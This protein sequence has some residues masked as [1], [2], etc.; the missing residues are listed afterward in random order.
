MRG[1]TWV[2]G[3]IALCFAGT[4]VY[5]AGELQRERTSHQN[6][7]DVRAVNAPSAI[8]EVQA[9]AA[10]PEAASLDKVSS[11][12]A[13]ARPPSRERRQPSE[14]ELQQQAI[15]EGRKFLAEISTPAGR[16]RALEQMKLM[17]RARPAGL[18][19]FLHMDAE[20]YSQFVDLLAAQ[21]LA[22]REI[23]L[24]CI[25][26]KDCRYSGETADWSDARDREI[27]SVFGQETVERYRWFERSSNE[28]QAVTE[29]R[30]HLP[31]SARLTDAKAE[32]LVKAWVEEME[33]IRRDMQRMQVGVGTFNGLTFVVM[34]SDP[35][36]SRAAAAD[37]YNR[38]MRERAAGVLTSEQLAVL[39]QEQAE[40]IE[41]ARTFHQLS[42]A[43]N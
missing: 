29:L 42:L 12:V 36:G 5:F 15:E 38:R 11:D 20:Q 6:S 13:H 2:L 34:E 41:Q 43:G 28:R 37:D 8:V 14:E 22:Q 10:K 3:A 7:A 4:T 24:R 27:A 31:D 33:L 9:A 1:L 16:A 39:A 17:V 32:E 23:S 26:D 19:K 40:A 35:D 25:L 30:G 21:E 18:A